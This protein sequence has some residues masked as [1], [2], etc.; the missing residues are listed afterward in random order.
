MILGVDAG[1]RTVPQAEHLLHTVVKAL[2]LPDGVIGCTHFVRTGT[3]G[4]A[5]SLAVPESV[6]LALLPGD[7]SA[8]LGGHRRGPQAEGAA[9][10]AAEHAARQG[11]RVVLFPGRAGLVGSL[12][13]G[14][15]LER[16]AIDRI[17]VLAQADPPAA[18][19]VV[20]TN[21]Y[22]RPVWREGLMTLLTM[23]AKGGR[24]TPAEVPNPTPCCA[25][26]A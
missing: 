4:V 15:L 19:V 20:A 25:D 17:L 10:A 13:V 23:P 6:D 12:T 26:H 7:V 2:G 14:E 8:A 3:P 1:S 16:S 22:V 24:L 11:G 5:C 21:D 9:L 18:E